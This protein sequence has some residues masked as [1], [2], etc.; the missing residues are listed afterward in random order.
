MTTASGILMWDLVAYVKFVSQFILLFGACFELPVVVMGLV[1]LDVLNYRMMKGTRSWAAV[2]IAVV[3]A[4]I[5]PT[6]DMLTLSLLAVPMYVLYEICIWLAYFMEKKDRQLNPEYYA[7]IEREEEAQKADE[8]AAWDNEDYNPWSSD[9][10]GEDEDLAARRKSTETTV[11]APA[12]NEPKADAEAEKTLE[13]SS[14]ED[15]ERNKD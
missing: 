8:A 7:D 3:A 12:E 4:V 9:D 6:Q 13:E 1:K 10:D 2:I 15:E 14:R 11:D 5:T